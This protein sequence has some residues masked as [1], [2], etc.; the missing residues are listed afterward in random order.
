MTSGNVTSAGQL[1][2]VDPGLLVHAAPVIVKSKR[3]Q[4]PR[5]SNAGRMGDIPH[6]PCR[7]ACVGAV[8]LSPRVAVV[9]P[10]P[11][12]AHCV[13]LSIRDPCSGRVALKLVL[14]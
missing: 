2:D 5:G 12:H 14:D 6:A 13:S 11:A 9:R 7:T 1:H 10:G 8:A 3:S 4:A